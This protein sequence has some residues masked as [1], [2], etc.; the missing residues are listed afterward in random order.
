MS[1]ITANPLASTCKRN[2]AAHNWHNGVRVVGQWRT[3]SWRTHVCF[4]SY[5]SHWGLIAKAYSYE[6]HTGMCR[7]F[8]DMFTCSHVCRKGG[9]QIRK[10]PP[11][12]R[13]KECLLQ[14]SEIPCVVKLWL[15]QS[16]TYYWLDLF[17]YYFI[18]SL[19]SLLALVRTRR[20]ILGGAPICNQDFVWLCHA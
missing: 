5:A 14:A 15:V 8:G 12:E 11:K 10:G 4:L 3:D 17:N 2:Y 18:G 1:R 9:A 16:Y 20:R 19:H 7:T 6:Y 13:A